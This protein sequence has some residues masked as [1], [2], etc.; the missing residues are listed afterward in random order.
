[1]TLLGRLWCITIYKKSIT[2]QTLQLGI[3][4]NQESLRILKNVLLP[5]ITLKSDIND[6]KNTSQMTSMPTNFDNYSK[7][8][9][10]VY[11]QSFKSMQGV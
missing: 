6:V 4:E 9:M 5:E 10:L 7:D 1:M 11:I 3:W 8:S 2:L